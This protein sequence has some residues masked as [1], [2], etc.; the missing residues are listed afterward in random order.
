MLAAKSRIDLYRNE[1]KRLADLDKTELDA[2]QSGEAVI[3]VG[4]VDPVLFKHFVETASFHQ[5]MLFL[6]PDQR[7]YAQKHYKGPARLAGVSGSGKTCVIVHRALWLAN[8]YPDEK[9]LVLTLNSALANLIGDLIEAAR[10]EGQ[11]KNI[12][13]LPFWEFCRNKLLTYEPGREA[14][15]TKQTIASNPHAVSEHIDEIWSEY[16]LCEANYDVADKMFPLHRSLLNRGIYPQ[17]YLR[18]EFE[19]IRSS[20]APEERNSYLSVER[21]GRVI[22]L[23]ET[24]RQQVIDGLAGWE[25]KMEAVGAIDDIGIVSALHR[26][27]DKI[28]PE[29]RCVLVDEVQDFGTLELKLIRKVVAEK[30]NDIFLCG[31]A[32]QSVYTKRHDPRVAGV[33]LHGRYESLKKNYRNSRQILEAAYAVLTTNFEK[34]SRSLNVDLEILNPEFANFT[35][36]KPL[37]L[38]ADNFVDELRYALGYVDWIVS[39]RGGQQKI[40]IVLCGYTQQSVELIGERLNIH[41]LSGDS[42]ITGRSIFLSDLE[43]TKGFE[44][45][46]VLVL[47]CGSGVIPHPELPVEES[48][49]DLFKL[50]VA[51]TRAKVELIISYSGEVSSFVTMA[52]DRFTSSSF[53]EYAEPRQM[54]NIVLPA[55]AITPKVDPSRWLVDG[56]RFLKLR[57]AVGL[58]D[59]VQEEIM[60]HV[61]GKERTVGTQRNRYQTEWKNFASF[62]DAMNLGPLARKHV[63]GEVAW[64][65]IKT[66]FS[67]VVVWRR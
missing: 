45:D 17:E 11:P 66:H 63:I 57:D 35:S 48:F 49:R 16:Y 55:P 39:E 60:D 13:V 30:E 22:P 21:A 41:V 53:S 4:D 29:Y 56:R 67:G 46:S 40:C 58:P 23:T 43:Q 31:D 33:D 14:Y 12:Q 61:T 28:E 36:P 27:L 25:K 5:W 34:T 9:I 19:Y 62:Y 44:F 15:Y 26:H 20:L 38:S 24:F 32:A 64:E 50:Y 52:L 59:N 3:R 51:M 18:Q 10:G 54:E 7:E 6:H 8:E 47:N 37:L 1:V 65:A 2:I 42:D